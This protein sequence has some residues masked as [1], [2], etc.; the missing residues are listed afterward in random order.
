MK[1]KI[2]NLAAAAA[3]LSTVMAGGHLRS[4]TAYD[5]LVPAAESFVLKNGIKVF[6]VGDELPQITIAASVGYGKLYEKKDT[7]GLSDLLARTLSISG[8]RKYPGG[9]MHE[10]VD[11]A[12]GQISVA[13]SWE[14]IVVSVK[15]LKKFAPLAF[16]VLSDLVANPNFDEKYFQTAKSI[17]SAHIKKKF[18]DPG[19][20]AIEKLREVIFDGEGYGSFPTHPCGRGVG[21]AKAFRRR[22][23]H[24]RSIELDGSGGR[25]NRD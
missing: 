13:S 21:L 25:K 17:Y 18:D 3:L 15:V 5:K 22:Q 2:K 6:Y 24:H 8:S 10:A 19:N 12:G 14:G 11:S 9:K 20:L 23:H 16:D 7:A 4:E 1:R